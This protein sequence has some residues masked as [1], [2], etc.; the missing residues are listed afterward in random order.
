MKSRLALLTRLGAIAF[1][2]VL[3]ACAADALA[4]QKSARS[5]P[6]TGSS[7]RPVPPQKRV[8]L[9]GIDGCRPDSLLAASTPV[10]D[11]LIAGGAYT[12]D[13]RAQD[14]TLSGPNWASMLTGV[15]PAKHGVLDNTFVGSDFVTYPHFFVHVKAVHPT[16]FTASIA[17]WSAIDTQIVSGADLSVGGITDE[18]VA[19]QAVDLLVNGD[20]TVVFLH[21]ND[22]DLAGHA[23]GFA[24]N[25]PQYTA[26]IQSTD[27]R[28]GTVISALNQRTATG[29]RSYEDWLVVVSTDHGGIQRNHG[30]TT[31]Q[32]ERTFLI[33]SGPSIQQGVAIPGPVD[34]VDVPVTVLDHLGIAPPAAWNLDGA[35][36]LPSVHL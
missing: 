5:A 35:S 14:P 33:L 9:I 30:G 19:Q 2:W 24:S 25:V 12:D 23:F 34:I 22:V 1:A 7:Q 15:T 3:L 13:A 29:I 36:V 18:Q 6:P 4:F 11:A 28:V 21:M 32:E 16:A 17:Q 10:I 27:A 26:A 20:P 8:L 31:M